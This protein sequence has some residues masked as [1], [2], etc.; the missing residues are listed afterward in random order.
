MKRYNKK[1]LK[2]NITLCLA[3]SLLYL[4]NNLCIKNIN[5]K[6]KE[7]FAFFEGYFNDLLC[8]FV[9]FGAINTI[10]LLKR[11]TH[12]KKLYILVSISLILGIIWEIFSPKMYHR[13]V[14]DKI[15]IVCYLAGTIIYWLFLSFS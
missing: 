1:K 6:N 3:G 10:L 12:I 2:L 14:T 8:P 11:K 9:V 4:L 7:L 15:D 13:Y 5:F